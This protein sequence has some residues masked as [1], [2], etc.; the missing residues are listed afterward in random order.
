M[1]RIQFEHLLAEEMPLLRASARNFTKNIEDSNDL[2]QDTLLKALRFWNSFREGTNFKGWLYTI[3]RNTF[4]DSCHFKA[5]R[6]Y[7]GESADELSSSHLLYGA[8]R[9][10]AESKMALDDIKTAIANLKSDLSEP[11][12]MYYTGYRYQEIA[13]HLSV[14]MGTIKTR[15]HQARKILQK[16]LLPY[17]YQAV[18]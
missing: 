7:E 15:I 10:F 14:P 6:R 8:P 1:E 18:G 5:A 3:M 17:Y 9:D 13:E 12:S 4:I 11:F 2:I 16:G